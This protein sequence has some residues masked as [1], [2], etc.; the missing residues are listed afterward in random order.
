MINVAV[1]WLLYERTGT[2]W[3]LG[4]VG[5]VELAPILFLMVAAG[6]AADRFP[7][8]NIG[9]AA[10]GL[11][12]VAAAGLAFVSAQDGPTWVIY[13]LLALVGTAR[14]F[15]APAV[16]TILPQLL[17]PAEFANANAWLA[18][19][20]QLASIIGPA[21]GGLLIAATGGAT[22]AFAAAAVGQ[23]VFVMMLRTMPVR[24]P[25][26][27][28]SKRSAQDVFAGFRFVRA[29]PL[30]LAAIT[31]DLFAV[32]FGGAVA[33]LPIFAKDILQ[34]GPAGLGWLRA[35]PG[36]GAMT[37]ALVTTRIKPWSRPGVALLWVVAGFGVAMIGFG[38]SRSFALSLVCLYFTGVFDN[39]SVVIR[40]T[41]EQMITPDHL[42]GR[43]AA[44][45]YVFIGFSNEFGAFESG[46]T[47]ALFGPTLSVVGGGFATLIVVLMVHA[48]WPQLSRI[49]PLH[50]LSPGRRR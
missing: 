24:T 50:T 17:A 29:N 10:H 4:L 45:N 25:A 44:I 31:L 8:R 39:V 34:V 18:T 11:L 30:F 48:I 47:A 3:A 40:L 1:G 19:T 15:S 46:A 35:A 33:L 22:A 32:L 37:M 28:S 12:T 14:A 5:A 36:L 2:A 49:G 20:Y 21:A 23:A 43:V 42:R 6:N 13:S 16:N 38:L 27:T 7:R 9:I 41:L 26:A